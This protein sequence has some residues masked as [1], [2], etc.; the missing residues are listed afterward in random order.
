MQSVLSPC[1]PPRALPS[2]HGGMKTKPPPPNISSSDDSS[3]DEFKKKI[4]VCKT[5]SGSNLSSPTMSDGVDLRLRTVQTGNVEP[6]KIV[7][8]NV[9]KLSHYSVVEVHLLSAAECVA[10]LCSVDVLKSAVP[11]C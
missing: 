6:T 9:S 4:V 8:P 3:D 11:Y 5:A 7:A 10:V 2:Y 1:S